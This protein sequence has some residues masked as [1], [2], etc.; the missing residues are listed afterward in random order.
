MTSIEQPHTGRPR[1]VL[2]ALLPVLILC[3]SALL[4]IVAISR[5]GF[6]ADDFLN[7]THFDRS[8]GQ[9]SNDHIN[10]G[11]YIINLFWG[12]GTEAFG[13]GSVVPFLL[14]NCLVLPLGG[15]PLV[16]PGV[17]ARPGAR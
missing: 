11:K 8:L 9:L 17:P 2:V 15:L 1:A 5:S 13:T 4:A 3:V 10:T 16:A 12:L 14:A 6:W 7:L